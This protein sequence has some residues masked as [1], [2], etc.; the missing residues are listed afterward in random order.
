[1][2]SETI[3]VRNFKP[4]IILYHMKCYKTHTKRGFFSKLFAYF[5]KNFHFFRFVYNFCTIAFDILR[6]HH[7]HE[8][9]KF[10][11]RI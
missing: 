8:V 5:E 9:K 4:I 1:M 10:F 11:F 6:T 2:K 3:M 7:D